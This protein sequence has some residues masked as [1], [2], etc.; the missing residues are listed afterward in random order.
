MVSQGDI[1]LNSNSDSDTKFVGTIDAS[2]QTVTKTG[3]GTLKIF[4]G[5]E[6]NPSKSDKFV[7]DAGR[8]D[9]KGYFEG[10]LEIEAG[11]VL[12][13]GNSIGMLDIDGTELPS[14][15]SALILHT[16]STLLME[17]AGPNPDD[18]DK[19][20]VDG[21]FT[22]EEGAI[23]NLVLYPSD[24]SFSPNETFYAVIQA[25]GT[26]WELIKDA[27]TSPH[28]IDLDVLHED[29]SNVYTITG[30][31]D[32]NV[33]PEPSTWALLILGAAGLLFWRKR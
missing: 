8:L 6:D 18:N 17:I 2:G 9:F 26:S 19:L 27:L 28:F 4:S 24:Y 22:I 23:I 33:V 16:A 5:D 31:V 32:P 13:P 20:I 15:V 12:S 29:G 21:N 25:D 11:A 7:V 14:D 30:K 10:S 1:T 3:S